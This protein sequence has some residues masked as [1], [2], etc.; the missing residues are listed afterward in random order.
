MNA[1]AGFTLIIKSLEEAF[2]VNMGPPIFVVPFK[3]D[4][5]IALVEE[6]TLALPD[7]S[8][9]DMDPWTMRISDFASVSGFTARTHERTFILKPS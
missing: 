4:L 3:Q 1:S 6:V 8:D 5:F 9:P 7:I 2:K